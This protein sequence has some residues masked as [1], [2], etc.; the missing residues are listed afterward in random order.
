MKG[1]GGNCTGEVEGAW[2]LNGITRVVGSTVR[3]RGGRWEEGG[4]R[5][6]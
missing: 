2:M 5:R 1:V 3:G 6:H 4:E